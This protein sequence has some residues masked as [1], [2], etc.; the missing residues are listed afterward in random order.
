MQEYGL[1]NSINT[2]AGGTATIDLVDTFGFGL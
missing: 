2:L 1:N